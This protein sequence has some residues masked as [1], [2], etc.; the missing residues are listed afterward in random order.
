LCN[1]CILIWCKFFCDWNYHCFTLKTV[2]IQIPTF[3]SFCQHFLM[4]MTVIWDVAPC[5]LA[6]ERDQHFT[7]V[8]GP[9][10]HN[11]DDEAT[12]C[13]IPEGSHLHT[14]ATARTWNLT[15]PWVCAPI[16]SNKMSKWVLR[17]SWW[18]AWR[19]IVFWDVV[20]CSL[21]DI[22]RYFREA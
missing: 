9:H 2:Y 14:L 11:P 7:G 13:N 19:W 20:S 16:T 18:W 1:F 5:S 12:W 3:V 17:F 8:Y 22:D 6:E 21:V 4:K 15:I 10:H